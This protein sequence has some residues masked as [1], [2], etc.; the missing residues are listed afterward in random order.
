VRIVLAFVLKSDYVTH[1]FLADRYGLIPRYL[2][3]LSSPGVATKTSWVRRPI[4]AVLGM[5]IRGVASTCNKFAHPRSRLP[6]LRRN[7]LH[8]NCAS[9][10]SPAAAP[11]SVKHLQRPD[12]SGRYGRFGGKYVPETLIPA[13]LE[14]E[15]AFVAI[16]ADPEFQA[17]FH[18]SFYCVYASVSE[19]L[20][21]G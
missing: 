7:R 2:R 17:K 20:V 6:R 4:M 16:K 11:S 19:F 12:A 21:A 15:T 1:L 9:V 8:L 18:S 5:E 13:L 10:V 14:L 3:W